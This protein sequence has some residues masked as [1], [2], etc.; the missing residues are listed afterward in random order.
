MKTKILIT[1]VLLGASSA[2]VFASG[3]Y[4]FNGFAGLAG[5]ANFFTENRTATATTTFMGVQSHNSTIDAAN[6]ST[7]FAG[8]LK[9][10]GTYTYRAF[11]LGLVADAQAQ[12]GKSP[13]SYSNTYLPVTKG[14]EVTVSGKGY[15]SM[16]FSFGVS[17]QPGLNISNNAEVYMALGGRIAQFKSHLPTASAVIDGSKD[18]HY[19]TNTAYNGSFSQWA[20]GAMLGLGFSSYFTSHLSVDGEYDY[21]YYF[22]FTKHTKFAGANHPSGLGPLEDVAIKYKP[23]TSNISLALTYHFAE[24]NFKQREYAHPVAWLDSIGIKLPGER[25]PVAA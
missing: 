11:T 16:P 22:P 25:P 14:P 21:T 24:E 13:L 19:G 4:G 15:E 2:T 10:G 3:F 5:G 1:A 20:P 9:L 23:F 17:L 7:G 12:T 18:I 8:D 6:D